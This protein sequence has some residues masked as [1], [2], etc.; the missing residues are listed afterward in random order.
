MMLTRFQMFD[1]SLARRQGVAGCA[2]RAA[3]GVPSLSHGGQSAPQTFHENRRPR[4]VIAGLPKA[5]ARSACNV[6]GSKEPTVLDTVSPFP[7]VPPEEGDRQVFLA[8]LSGEAE[9]TASVLAWLGDDAL[10]AVVNVSESL[11]QKRMAA[12][13]A[14]HATGRCSDLCRQCR[15]EFYDV[16][17]IGLAA[18]TSVM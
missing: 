11:L 4:G 8:L 14:L 6:P 16:T 15:Y 13:D 5:G 10:M 12:R 9:Q 17:P 18:I 1:A 3:G 2:P 7:T